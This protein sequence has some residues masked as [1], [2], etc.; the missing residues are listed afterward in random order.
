MKA[1]LIQVKETENEAALLFVSLCNGT[2]TT[3]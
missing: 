3:A 1:I 2:I